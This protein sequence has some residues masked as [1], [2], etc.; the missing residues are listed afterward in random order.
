[1]GTRLSPLCPRTRFRPMTVHE[2]PS[3]RTTSST[4]PGLRSRN[5]ITVPRWAFGPRVE[6]RVRV[7][8]TRRA[9]RSCAT[10]P[11]PGAA[12]PPCEGGWAVAPPGAV[13]PG[14]TP[15]P[16]APGGG[17]AAGGRPGGGASGGGGGTPGSGGGG[18]GGKGGGGGSG[19][20]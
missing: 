17:G 16:G 11:L 2:E 15:D 7:A 6:K 19:G 8:R 1:K 4:L 10:E 9:W 3:A 13:P 18:G 14:P 5:R 20:G 12:T